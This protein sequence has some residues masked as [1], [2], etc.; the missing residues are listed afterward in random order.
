VK[1]DID[2]FNENLQ[3]IGRESSNSPWFDPCMKYKYDTKI[4]LPTHTF[5]LSI[6]SN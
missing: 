5:V 1:A 3:E 6:Q 4:Y 2:G